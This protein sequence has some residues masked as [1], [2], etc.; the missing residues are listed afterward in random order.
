MSLSQLAARADPFRRRLPELSPTLAALILVFL[1]AA[2]YGLLAPGLDAGLYV[3]AAALALVLA[4]VILLRPE[5][6]LMLMFLTAPLETTYVDVAGFRIKPSQVIGLLTL[7]GWALQLAVGRRKAIRSSGL[8]KPL[9]L[10]MLTFLLAFVL[11]FQYLSYGISL[12]GLQLWFVAMIIVLAN[13]VDEPGVLRRCFWMFIIAGTLEA[14]LAIVQAAGFYDKVTTTTAYGSILN[15]ARPAGTFSE[16]DFLAPFLVGAFLLILPFWGSKR[17]GSWMPAVGVVVLLLLAASI[18][19]MVRASW[20]GMIAGLAVFGW[21]KLRERGDGLDFAALFK[22]M[23]SILAALAVILVA[24]AV[25]WPTALQTV[26][27]RAKNLVA[28]VEPE[29]PAPTR[30]QEMQQAWAVIKQNPLLGHG[31]G[32]IAITTEYGRTVAASANSGRSGVV[33]AGIELGLLH[34]QGIGGLLAF[35]LLMGVLLWRL[36]RALK[37]AGTSL[38]YVQGAIACVVGLTI[39]ACFNNL[40]YF[41]YYWLIIALAAAFSDLLL[42]KS[43]TAQDATV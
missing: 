26:S 12:F 28:I 21:L 19:A 30:A 41:A 5:I 42:S 35:A 29:N 3:P 6:G 15:Q 34:D 24:L 37:K 7:A 43:P 31:V 36:L 22:R 2:A 18:L 13:F 40:Y 9:A 4:A 39:S 27:V 14:A 17:T 11:H 1:T 32:T 8:T 25:V 23:T 38:P 33:G 16:P 20:L 10:L